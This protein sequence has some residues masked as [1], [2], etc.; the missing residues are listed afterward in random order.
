MIAIGGAIGTG[1]FFASGLADS[2][3]DPR[4]MPPTR[5]W[6]WRVLHDAVAG[7]DGTQLPIPARSKPTR[8]L[9]R[10]VNG[11]PSAGITGSAGRST[12][13]AEL[14]AGA[15]IV[16]FWSQSNSTAWVIGFFVMLLALNLLRC[17]HARRSMVSSI[18]VVT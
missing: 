1:L 17:G 11:F 14:V 9:R 6:P 16:Q 12:L 15:L 2:Q 8:T 10:S 4:A 18:K 13:A 7:R 5:S 3:R